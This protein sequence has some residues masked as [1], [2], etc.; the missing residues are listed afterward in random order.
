M[1]TRALAAAT[2]VGLLWSPVAPDAQE[3][4]RKPVR[5]GRLSPSSLEADTSRLAAFRKGL[6]ELGWVEGRDFVVETR[7]AEGRPERFA[8]LAA[9]FVRERVDLILVG[10]N[11]GALAAK[12]ATTTIPIVMVTTGDPVGG[13]LI[14]SFAR[15]G[16]NLTGVTALGQALSVK[17]LSLLKEIVP[18]ASRVAVLANPTSPH[19][20]PFLRERETAART[21]GIQIHV[22]EAQ[23]STK[24][25]RAFTAITAERPGALL[26]LND[27]MF[28]ANRK[29]IVELAT[30]TRLPVMYS[31]REFVNVGG[32]L[33]YGASLEDM[34]HRAAFHADRILKGTKPADLPVEQ[35]TR[36]ELV[37]NLKTARALGL[38]ISPSVLA[39]ADDVIQ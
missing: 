25:D 19:T 15:P 4:P 13:G 17:R 36:L 18:T 37:I 39:R 3:G 7:S 14:A 33:F 38:T 10:S 31:E 29:R 35:P 28:I 1:L 5:I 9:D 21:L 24:L 8:P 26:V 34:Y 22:V 23:D 16:G 27:V 11:Q 6:R 12:Q 32:L 2:V 20:P 30:Q